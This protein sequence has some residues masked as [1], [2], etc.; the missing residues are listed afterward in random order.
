[1]NRYVHQ[2][3]FAA[4]GAFVWNRNTVHDGFSVKVG[5]AVNT[6]AFTPVR[7]RQMYDARM[8]VPAPFG[9][10]P[11]PAY[12][13]NG[14]GLAD[15]LEAERLRAEAAEAANGKLRQEAF[16]ANKRA[17][18]AESKLKGEGDAQPRS[19][20]KPAAP[21]GA[22]AP[23]ASAPAGKAPAQR[24]GNSKPAAKPAPKSATRRAT[25]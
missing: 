2:I 10:A 23:R 12:L 20:A 24:M 16:D 25:R 22:D 21:R 4:E 17:A 15:K 11:P 1:M 19:D 14:V 8:I 13:E 5:D 6:A 7:L 3:P 18:A 9:D